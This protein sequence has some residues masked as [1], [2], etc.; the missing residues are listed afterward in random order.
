MKLI[1][2]V[3]RLLSIRD[4]SEKEIRD[5]V[6]RRNF[7]FKMVHPAS[8]GKGRDLITD[9]EVDE[10]IKTLKEKGFLDDE[11]FA[12]S[13]VESRSRKYGVNKIKQELAQKGI[14][15][16]RFQIPNEEQTMEKLLERKL[17]SWKSLESLEFKKKATEFLLR[18]GFE[19]G[20]AQT[21]VEN[22]MKKSYNS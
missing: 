22:L 21:A 19:F 20:A 16:F 1:E 15:D 14:R 8:G 7:K 17:K 12:Q 10:V 13:W 2:R 5:Y 9:S 11:R 6:K 18:R 3:Y 4:R